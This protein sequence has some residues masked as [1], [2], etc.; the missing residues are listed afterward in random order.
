MHLQGAVLAED[1]KNAL[2]LLYAQLA[3]EQMV[4]RSVSHACVSVLING[5]KGREIGICAYVLDYLPTRKTRPNQTK[6][7]QTEL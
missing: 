6:P 5:G 7:D 1:L 4:E 3:E 2:N